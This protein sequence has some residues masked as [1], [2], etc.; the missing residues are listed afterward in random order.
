MEDERWWCMFP[1]EDGGE[2]ECGCLMPDWDREILW[3]VGRMGGWSREIW[4]RWNAIWVPMSICDTHLS[5]HSYFCIAFQEY[6]TGWLLAVYLRYFRMEV[7]PMG[8]C[9]TPL[10]DLEIVNKHRLLLGT[11]LHQTKKVLFLLISNKE[12]TNMLLHKDN[13]W[14]VL[15]DSVA[16]VSL[17]L[18]STQGN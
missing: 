16:D 5:A 2:C 7:T 17:T 18:S 12:V 13:K 11:T 15:S 3:R 8:W 9:F 10:I 6:N 14:H 4:M 1:S